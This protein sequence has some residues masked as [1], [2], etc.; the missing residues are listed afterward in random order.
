VPCNGRVT[1]QSEHA[2]VHGGAVEWLTVERG[3]PDLGEARKAT[4]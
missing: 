2:G 4:R 1:H 3:Y